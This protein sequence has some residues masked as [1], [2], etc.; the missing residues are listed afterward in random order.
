LVA[1]GA[2]TFLVFLEQ[3][4]DAA[5]ST[6]WGW[7][8]WGKSES[9]AAAN[10]LKRRADETQEV[11]NTRFEE[12]KRKAGEKGEDVKRRLGETEEEFRDRIAKAIQ[13]R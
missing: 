7:L 9:R 6:G 10:D 4:V 1:P 11:W 2:L 12:A 5:K 13:R 8:N 3:K